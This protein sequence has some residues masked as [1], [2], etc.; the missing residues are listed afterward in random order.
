MATRHGTQSGQLFVQISSTWTLVDGVDSLVPQGGEKTTISATAINDTSAKSVAGLPNEASFTG[1]IFY[2]PLDSAHQHLLTLFGSGAIASFRW[3]F[4]PSVTPTRR[5]VWT[6]QVIDF[7]RLVGAN[8]SALKASLAIS[9]QTGPTEEA[10][11][12]TGA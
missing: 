9:I 10:G 4:P 12:G 5:M 2:D 11:T 1:E 3:V 6:G 8:N 7:K